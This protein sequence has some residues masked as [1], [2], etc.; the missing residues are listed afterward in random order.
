M[1]HHLRFLG[2]EFQALW[3]IWR[4]QQI[5][6]RQL[7]IFHIFVARCSHGISYWRFIDRTRSLKS[8]EQLQSKIT[9]HAVRHLEFPHAALHSQDRSI[10]GDFF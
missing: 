6:W 2:G 3:Q 5:V 1:L 4:L 8:S 10:T 7:S 9:Y